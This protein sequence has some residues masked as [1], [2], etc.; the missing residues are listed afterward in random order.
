VSASTDAYVF[1][2]YCWEDEDV[3]FD[4]EAAEGAEA[5]LAKFGVSWDS[6]CSVSCPIPFLYVEGTKTTAWRGYP[7]PLT[8]LEVDPAW[9]GRLAAFLES[10]GID[11]P[12]GE[13]QPGWWTASWTEAV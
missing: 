10:Q 9:Q 3:E 13:N 5:E 2:G 7:K 12:E 8:S 4:L 11:A 1:F 6:H